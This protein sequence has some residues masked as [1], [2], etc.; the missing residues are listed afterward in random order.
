M[1]KHQVHAGPQGR[2]KKK[3]TLRPLELEPQMVMS[4]HGVL[5]TELKSSANQGALLAID[6]F[7]A[8]HATPG[9]A[10]ILV[11]LNKETSQRL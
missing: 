4:H 5:G 11:F 10:I 3:K 9:M 1:C 2:Q 6:L 8:P 7:P